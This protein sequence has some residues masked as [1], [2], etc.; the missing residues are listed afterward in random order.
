MFSVAGTSWDG[1]RIRT[2][3]STHNTGDGAHCDRDRYAPDRSREAGPVERGMIQDMYGAW[4]K[5]GQPRDGW[6]FDPTTGQAE[7]RNANRRK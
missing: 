2:G 5:D 3:S 7:G 4:Q 1:S 6:S